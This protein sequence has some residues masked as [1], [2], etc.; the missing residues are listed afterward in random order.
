[1]RGEAAGA[2][3][4]ETAEQ[5]LAYGLWG[6]A[7]V[8]VLFGL[9][10]LLFRIP[11]KAIVI[12][13]AAKSASANARAAI[14]SNGVHTTEIRAYPFLVEDLVQFST[15]S[16]ED[17]RLTLRRRFRSDPPE[18]VWYSAANPRKVS[19][20]NPLHCFGFACACSI[21]ALWLRW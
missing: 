17:I 16:G 6:V 20:I 11:A 8:A 14:I 15:R 21:T 1:M 12:F 19:A 9:H 10:T 2:P 13:D 5:L 3:V 4:L 18:L 7:A